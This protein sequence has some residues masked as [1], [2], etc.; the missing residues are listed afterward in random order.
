MQAL[1]EHL[2]ALRLHY[3][4]VGEEPEPLL[5]LRHVDAAF[6]LRHEVMAA[7]VGVEALVHQVYLVA[8]RIDNLADGIG[9]AVVAYVQGEVMA[10]LR[11][12]GVQ[13]GGKER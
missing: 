7:K 9:T 2:H 4:V 1:V 13:G 11:R 3:V 5:T 8:I 6:P 10:R 12:D